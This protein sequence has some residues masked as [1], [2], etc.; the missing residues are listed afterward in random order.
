MA[1]DREVLIERSVNPFE[2]MRIS[3]GGIFGGVLTGVGTL[4][5]LTTL[6]LAIGVSAVDPQ[7]TEG[8]TVGTGAAVW[9]ALTLLIA[10]FMG[11]WASTRLS[12]LWEPTTA[13]FEGALVWVLSMIVI[14]YLTANGI[15]L[16][17]GGAFRLAGNVAQTAAST[18]GGGIQDLSSG[19]VDQML[20]RLRDPQ[21]ATQ[22]AATLRMPREEVSAALA[23]TSQAVETSRDNPSQAAEEVRRGMQP[24]IDRAQQRLSQTAAAVQPEAARTAWLTFAALLLSLVAAIAGAAAGRRNAEKR[25]TGET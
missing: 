17:A 19:D 23:S 9:T 13:M 4:L 11:G 20:A 10:L 2:G 7:A 24:L 12:M 25:A 22:L 5:L 8:S 18:V 14:L 6:G 3:W 1:V 15:G 21:T 16:V